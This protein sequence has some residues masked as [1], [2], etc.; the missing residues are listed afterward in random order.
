MWTAYLTDLFGN[1][2]G[3][4][5]NAKGRKFTSPFLGV[6]TFSGIIRLDHPRANDLLTKDCLVKVYRGGVLA[7]NGPVITAQEVGNPE[8]QSMA[9]VAASVLWRGQRRMVGKSKVGFAYGTGANLLDRSEIDRRVLQEINAEGYT[10][11]SEGSIVASSDGSI[12]PDHFKPAAE[13]WADLAASFMGPEFFVRPT[14]PT[15]G[16]AGSGGWPQ[17]GL[18]DAKPLIGTAKPHLVFQYGGSNFSGQRPNV[19]EYER[20]RDLEGVATRVWHLPPGFPDGT[21]N[22]P[23]SKQDTAA[24]TARGLY[25]AVVDA[26]LSTISVRDALLDE[27]LRIRKAQ[28]EIILFTPVRNARPAP[29]ADYNVGDQV[30]GRAFVGDKQRFDAMFR[31][32]G[33]DVDILDS[34]DEDTTLEL[35]IP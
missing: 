19:S 20:K 12:G 4:L 34:G 35:M 9:F 28:R 10:G 7:L 11:I 22:L 31:V 18:F 29:I 6:P 5:L 30:R 27:H 1:V 33:I 25:D 15:L 8:G 21:T 2:L 13:I 32:W 23:R 24:I 26:D 17:L 16:I 3:P 14:E